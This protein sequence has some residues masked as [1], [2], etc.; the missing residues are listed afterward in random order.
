MAEG[1]L[2]RDPEAIVAEVDGEP[3]LLQLRSWTYASLNEV[4]ARIW[5]LLAEPRDPESLVRAL[6]EEFEGDEESIRAEVVAFIDRL[7]SDGFL[8]RDAQNPSRE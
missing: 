2:R 4:G 1:L 8:L 7:R 5:D 3:R 6:L